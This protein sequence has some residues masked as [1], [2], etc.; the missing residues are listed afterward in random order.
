MPAVLKLGGFRHKTQQKK[1]TPALTESRRYLVVD[2]QPLVTTAL[3]MLIRQDDPGCEVDAANDIFAARRLVAEKGEDADLLVLDLSMPGVIGT[4]LL[5]EFVREQPSLKILV[6]SGLTDRGTILN[7]LQRGAAGFVPKTLDAELLTTAIRFVLKGGV[8]LPSK[9][10]A[11]SQRFGFFAEAAKKAPAADHSAPPQ[12]T[13][14]QTDVLRELAKGNPIK[15]IC[16]NLG[17]S[18]G[19][20]KTHV[21]AIYRAFGATNRTEALIAA[22]RAGFDISL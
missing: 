14:R 11:E 10:I 17:L 5:E 22:H 9:I 20:V 13:P 15:R 8:Y 12:L 21:S 1:E 16:K 4:S 19:T 2:D 3:S 18:E 6:L 7:V